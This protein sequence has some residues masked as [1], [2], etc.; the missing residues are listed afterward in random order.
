MGGEAGAEGDEPEITLGPGSR[1]SALKD[2]ENGWTAHIAEVAQ[3]RRDVREVLP[4]QFPIECEENLAAA[5]M[6]DDG[7][8]RSWST[9]FKENGDRLGG[10]FRDSPVEPVA[11]LNGAGFETKELPVFRL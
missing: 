11:Q 10:R 7:T 6:G 1:E 5:G 4:G 8:D 9:A 3:H 2:K